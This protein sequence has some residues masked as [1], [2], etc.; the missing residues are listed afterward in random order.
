MRGIIDPPVLLDTPFQ[1]NDILITFRQSQNVQKV[2]Q[3]QSK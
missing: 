1:E 2:I 3:S